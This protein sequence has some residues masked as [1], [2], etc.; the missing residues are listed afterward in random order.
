[1]PLQQPA[2]SEAASSPIPQAKP[3]AKPAARPASSPATVSSAAPSSVDTRYFVQVGVFAVED[4]ALTLQE[5][6]EAAGFR[7]HTLG[8]KTPK[9]V[10][11]QVRVG[12]F[13]SKGDADASAAQLKAM[14]LPTYIFKLKS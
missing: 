14:D 1:M 10:L 7:V 9:G 13:D 2:V 6:L 12:P 3:L 11:I 8:M 5:K 4:N